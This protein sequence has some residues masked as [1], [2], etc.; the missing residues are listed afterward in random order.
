MREATNFAREGVG[1]KNCPP[2]AKF[3]SSLWFTGKVAVTP[4]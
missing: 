2:F 1:N 3:V 4:G